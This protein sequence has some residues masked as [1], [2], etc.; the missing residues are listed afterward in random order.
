MSPAQN[1]GF[2]IALVAHASGDKRIVAL[3]NNSSLVKD[4]LAKAFVELETVATETQTTEPVNNVTKIEARKQITVQN[5]DE[6]AA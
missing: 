2:S 6:E 3:L 1:Y 4:A 5:I